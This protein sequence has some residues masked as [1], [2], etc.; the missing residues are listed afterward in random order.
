MEWPEG[1]VRNTPLS[2]HEKEKD[3]FLKYSGLK[4]QDI[5]HTW[6][7]RSMTL[8]EC[9]AKCL[10][11]CSCMA[12]TN[13]DIRGQGSGCVLWFDDLIDIKQFLSCGGQDLY[14]CMLDSELGMV[15]ILSQKIIII[16]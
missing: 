9:R 14:S 6:V 11:N 15:L 10:C 2:C 3:G 16:I 12:Y 13:A 4:L 1:C 8:K 7:N 5:A